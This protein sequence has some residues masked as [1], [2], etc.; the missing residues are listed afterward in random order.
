MSANIPRQT[1]YLF[2]ERSMNV[3]S[4]THSLPLVTITAPPADVT[5]VT[6]LAL[7]ITVMG[8]VSMSQETSDEGRWKAQIQML[9]NWIFMIDALITFHPHGNLYLTVHKWHHEWVSP[10]WHRHRPMSPDHPTAGCCRPDFLSAQINST[11]VSTLSLCSFYK[12][13]HF[14]NTWLLFTAFFVWWANLLTL[15]YCW[16]FDCS[17][18]AI[19]AVNLRGPAVS[20]IQNGGQG[21]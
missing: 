6:C 21:Q 14:W 2:T 19:I 4:C 11:S 3:F 20:S 13:L 5:F 12:I 1:L 10:W 8:S 18:C 9:P 7:M 15:H 16:S 17:K